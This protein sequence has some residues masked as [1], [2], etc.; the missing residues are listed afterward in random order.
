[1]NGLYPFRSATGV[2]PVCHCLK[3]PGLLKRTGETPAAL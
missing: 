1:M 2:L 3:S